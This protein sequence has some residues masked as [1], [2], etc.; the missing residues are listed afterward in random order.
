MRHFFHQEIGTWVR[1]EKQE[2]K[3]GGNLSLR[4]RR[5]EMLNARIKSLQDFKGKSPDRV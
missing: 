5:T 3:I 1:R 2:N 4:R